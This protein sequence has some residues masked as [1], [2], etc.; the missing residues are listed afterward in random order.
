MHQLTWPQE[1]SQAA[2]GNQAHSRSCGQVIPFSLDDVLFEMIN[3]AETST[4]QVVVD[5]LGK[6]IMVSNLSL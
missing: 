3:Q 5:D 1:T 6:I 4:V 2:V